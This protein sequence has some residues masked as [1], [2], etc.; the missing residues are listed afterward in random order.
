MVCFNIV[1]MDEWMIIHVCVLRKNLHIAQPWQKL[2]L[3]PLGGGE[4]PRPVTVCRVSFCLFLLLSVSVRTAHSLLVGL[5]CLFI[6][7]EGLQVAERTRLIT[8]FETRREGAIDRE[9]GKWV[10]QQEKKGEERGNWNGRNRAGTDM[11]EER[12]RETGRDKGKLLPPYAS[13]LRSLMHVLSGWREAV[14]CN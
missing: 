13:L 1:H 7:S 4:L 6:R 8:S 12:E 2:C 14:K 5:L 3:P 9:M 10:G 11:D